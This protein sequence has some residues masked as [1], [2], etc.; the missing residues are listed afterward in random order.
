MLERWVDEL[1]DV[2]DE[3]EGDEPALGELGREL[4][5]VARGL[6]ALDAER[7][8]HAL[9]RDAGLARAVR[10]FA[11]WQKSGY[12][13]TNDPSTFALISRQL[14]WEV[15]ANV[16][17]ITGIEP[18]YPGVDGQGGHTESDR[19]HAIER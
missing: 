13:T 5:A 11:E 14:W 15:A 3:L 10:A 2:A 7:E 8:D 17:D 9:G 12:L 16:R 18:P 1:M 19:S 4:R 6:Q